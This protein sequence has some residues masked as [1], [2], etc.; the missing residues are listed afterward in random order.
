MSPPSRRRDERGHTSILIVGFAIA[1][2]MG[3]AV[4]V[5]ASATTAIQIGRAH[6]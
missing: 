5:D 6:V 4:V 2:L 1:L 3:M